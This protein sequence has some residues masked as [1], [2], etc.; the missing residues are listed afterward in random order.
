MKGVSH[1]FEAAVVRTAYGTSFLLR[2]SG[3]I[4]A[5]TQGL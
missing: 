3:D 1:F 2:S 5:R 4:R